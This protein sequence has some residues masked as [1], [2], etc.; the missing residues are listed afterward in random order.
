MTSMIKAFGSAAALASTVLLASSSFTLPAQAQS[1]DSNRTC[2]RVDDITGIA[3]ADNLGPDKR[4]GVNIKVNMRDYYQLELL[5]PC[6][7]QLRD[8]TNIGVKSLSA[9]SYICKSTDAEVIAKARVMP[10][11]S[12]TVTSLRKLTPNEVA[13]LPKGQ[14]P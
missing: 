9:S 7:F 13:S 3:A 12:C 11:K 1:R 4:D 8:S 14:Q 10:S 2:F 5:E 6:G